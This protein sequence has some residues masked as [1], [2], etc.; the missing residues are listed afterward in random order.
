MRHIAFY[1]LT[2]D[3]DR[4]VYVSSIK[5][6]KTLKRDSSVTLDIIDN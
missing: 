5:D 4:V 6:L 2:F 3:R 1:D